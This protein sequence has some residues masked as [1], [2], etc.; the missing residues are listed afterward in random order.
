MVTSRLLQCCIGL[1]LLVGVLLAPV[2]SASAQN[3][4]ARRITLVVPYTP[5]SGFD[6]VART[7]GQRLQE[8][9][10]QPVV[11]DNKAGAS[12]TIGTEAVANAAPDGY[13][14][15]VSGGPHT[16]YPSLMKTLRFDPIAG[17]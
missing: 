14:L 11:I 2:S 13:T 1:G 15:L 17:F 12:G 3:Y 6:I 16:I 10:G 8:R 5:G 7:V 9:W 4:P